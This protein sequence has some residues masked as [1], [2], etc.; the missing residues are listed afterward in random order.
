MKTA[1]SL[2]TLILLLV[3]VLSVATNSPLSASIEDDDYTYPDDASEEEKQ[4]ID[5][6]EQEAWE[7]AGRPGEIDD[8]EEEAEEAD[9]NDS[10]SR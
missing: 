7:D 10:Y 8:P 5:E 1:N 6:R 3:A 4:E 2:I 9:E